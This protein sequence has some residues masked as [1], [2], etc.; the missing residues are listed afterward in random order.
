MEQLK[1]EIKTIPIGEIK[2]YEGSHNTDAVVDMLKQS[3]Q[4]FGIQQPISVDKDKVIVTGNAVYR[5]ALALGFKEMPCVVLEDLSEEEIRQYRIADNKT[6]EFAKWNEEKLRKELTCIQ[7]PDMLQFCFDENLQAMLNNMPEMKPIKAPTPKQEQKAEES[8]KEG[9][10]AA[11]KSMEAKP[12]EYFDY[13]CSNCHKK[14]T[15]KLQ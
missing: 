15:V 3:L 10:K 7:K 14:V 8:F 2:P 4:Q 9:I 1:K 13:I 5:A 11:E 12:T 6:S